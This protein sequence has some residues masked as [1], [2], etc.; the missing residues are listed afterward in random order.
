MTAA[1]KRWKHA[2]PAL[3]ICYA[4]VDKLCISCG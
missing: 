1:E 2:F 3:F 4:H